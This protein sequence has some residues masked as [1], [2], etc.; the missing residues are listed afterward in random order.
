MQFYHDRLVP[1]C[2]GY[3]MPSRAASIS[4]PFPAWYVVYR[5]ELACTI[6]AIFKIMCPTHSSTDGKYII[7]TKLGS[8][9]ILEPISAKTRLQIGLFKVRLN[10][11]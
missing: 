2:T 7:F 3:H 1:Y 10:L 5:V 11:I 9:K 8:V 4:D 6:D